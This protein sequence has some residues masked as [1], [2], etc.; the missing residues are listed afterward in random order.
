MVGPW[1]FACMNAFT[2]SPHDQVVP[3]DTDWESGIPTTAFTQTRFGL[4]ATDL[5]YPVEHQGRLALLFGDTWPTHKAHPGNAMN[6][7]D[8][9][10][11]WIT[12]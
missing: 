10:V 12:S 2:E 11:G 1:G 8:D 9:A 3:S 4:G 7:A 5:G 6:P